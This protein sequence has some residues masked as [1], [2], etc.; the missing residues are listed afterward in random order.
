MSMQTLVSEEEYLR[1]S[2]DGPEPDY[3]DGEI[4][5]RSMP[6]Y[7]HGYVQGESYH[8]FRM[9]EQRARLFPCPG[10]RIKVAPGRHR[11]VDLAVYADAPPVERVPTAPPLVALEVVSEDDSHRDIMDKLND[12][13]RMEVPNIWLADPFARRL[14]VYRGGD[15]RA[16]EAFELPEF[17]FRLTPTDILPPPETT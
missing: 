17:S 12:Y 7:G 1:T 15:L 4:V 6:V 3:I 10:L 13:H 11:V 8:L 9:A 14:W 16:V 5:E 2:F